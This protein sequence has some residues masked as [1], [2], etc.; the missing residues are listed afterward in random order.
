M[1]TFLFCLLATYSVACGLT[2]ANGKWV[3]FWFFFFLSIATQNNMAQ[4]SISPLARKWPFVYARAY[5]LMSLNWLWIWRLIDT[6]I[7][8]NKVLVIT[9][10]VVLMIL[11]WTHFFTSWVQKKVSMLNKKMRGALGGIISRALLVWV[12]IICLSFSSVC[13]LCGLYCD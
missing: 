3:L 8:K 1:D 7:R 9:S 12:Q 6:L 4:M 5:Q 13:E 10:Q 11:L 2:F